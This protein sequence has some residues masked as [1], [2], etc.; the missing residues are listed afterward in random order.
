[1]R[2][3][4]DSSSACSVFRMARMDRHDRSTARRSDACGFRYALPACVGNQV[5][6]LAGQLII[7]DASQ[8]LHRCPVHPCRDTVTVKNEDGML[9]AFDG[10]L[11][12]RPGNTPSGRGPLQPR[13]EGIDE[14]EFA[15]KMGILGHSGNFEVR[16]RFDPMTT[17]QVHKWGDGSLRSLTACFPVQLASSGPAGGGLL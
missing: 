4:E 2:Q 11:D 16:A 15:K 10:A 3:S 13:S 14:I 12:G 9:P 6:V 5:H 17:C 7:S 8:S 1:M